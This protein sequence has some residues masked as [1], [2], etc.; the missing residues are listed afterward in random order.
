MARRLGG[1]VSDELGLL[2]RQQTSRNNWWRN[3]VRTLLD[4]AGDK[5]VFKYT[6]THSTLT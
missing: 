2:R 6:T 1:E 3:V 5:A 4:M